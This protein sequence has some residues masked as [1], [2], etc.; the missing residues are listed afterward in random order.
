M[1]HS[2]QVEVSSLS[3]EFISTY[4]TPKWAFANLIELEWMNGLVAWWI[5]Q[6]INLRCLTVKS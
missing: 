4:V 3:Y 6:N 2:A 1:G 5:I